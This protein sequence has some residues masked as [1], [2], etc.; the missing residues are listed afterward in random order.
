[1]SWRITC[2][3]GH[4][5]TIDDAAELDRL[6][7]YLCCD[8]CSSAELVFAPDSI[9]LYCAQCGWQHGCTIDEASSWMA[10]GCPDCLL[11]DYTGSNLMVKGSQDY[12][13]TMYGAFHEKKPSDDHKIADRPD[14][15]E[16][17]THFC[18]RESFQ[19]ILRERRILAKPTGLYKAPA[20]CMTDAPYQV[21]EHFKRR[22]GPYGV[23]F[24]KHQILEY[25]GGPAVYLNDATID[26][27]ERH[28]G[29]A[30]EMVAFLNVYRIPATAPA[31]KRAKR[32]D[33]L[34]DREWRV[35]HDID[36]NEVRP[37]AFVTPPNASREVLYT[38][39]WKDMVQLLWEVPEM[40]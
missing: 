12:E 24:R 22:Y 32:I 7:D 30:P 27:Q 34:H 36:L 40:V 31:R 8:Q 25:G 2:K 20:V 18:R 14:Y 3:N 37:L 13:I 33:F 38:E 28:G 26:A 1:M 17:V 23:V 9:E 4:E 39:H 21:S 11:L 6:L 35:P 10:S 19:A 5:R 15:W 29:F 16:L